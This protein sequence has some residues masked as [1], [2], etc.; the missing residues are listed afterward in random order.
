VGR[1]SPVRKYGKSEGL[2][3]SAPASK[4]DVVSGKVRGIW[5]NF[6]MALRDGGRTTADLSGIFI[7][8]S[9]E[10]FSPICKRGK[11]EDLAIFEFANNITN[12]IKNKP[13]SLFILIS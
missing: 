6:G 8:G 1:S 13:F 7:K 2:P 5:F 3:T 10:C 11:S 12:I 4:V 9:V